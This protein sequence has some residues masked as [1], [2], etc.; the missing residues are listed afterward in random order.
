MWKVEL[1]TL[2]VDLGNFRRVSHRDHQS[3]V[4]FGKGA[5]YRFDDPMQ[6]FGVMYAGSDYMT[7]ISESLLRDEIRLGMRPLYKADIDVRVIASLFPATVTLVDLTDG[8]PLGLDGQISCTPDYAIAQDWAR[9]LYEHP[10]KPDG[11]YYI[12]RNYPKG[13]SIALF[14]RVQARVPV[15]EMPGTR[16][17]VRQ[18]PAYRDLLGQLMRAGIKLR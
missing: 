6:G 9:A 17:A 18:D 2:T 16:I 15:R 11:L 7:C 3:V 8:L 12:P 4:Y 14:D 5:V 1:P 13:I 10:S